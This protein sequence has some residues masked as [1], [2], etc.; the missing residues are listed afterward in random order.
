MILL[1]TAPGSKAY[2][3]VR[4]IIEFTQRTGITPIMKRECG[5][6]TKREGCL[7]GIDA[8]ATAENGNFSLDV[9][10]KYDSHTYAFSFR[11]TTSNMNWPSTT[12]NPS[13]KGRS[14]N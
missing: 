5:C 4:S 14:N 1:E 9:G 6:Y 7:C 8:Q 3:P 2:T 12:G 11:K 10:D 13:G